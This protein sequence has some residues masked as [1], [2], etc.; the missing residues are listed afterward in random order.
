MDTSHWGL[1]EAESKLVHRSSVRRK[2]DLDTSRIRCGDID[3]CLTS[4][5]DIFHGQTSWVKRCSTDRLT[6]S[7]STPEYAND[8]SASMLV[9]KTIKE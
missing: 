8:S 1:D 4:G 5:S 9:V 3:S 6:A 7:S 2:Q